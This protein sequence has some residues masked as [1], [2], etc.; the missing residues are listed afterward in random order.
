[1]AIQLVIFLIL[2]FASAFT[3]KYAYLIMSL[4]PFSAFILMIVIYFLNFGLNKKSLLSKNGFV[5]DV[6]N[7]RIEIENQKFK[8]TINFDDGYKCDEYE[9]MLIIIKDKVPQMILPIRAVDPDYRADIQAIIA[10]GTTP[11]EQ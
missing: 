6:F 5:V 11:Y 4:I 7:D 8:K 9:N 2:A 10:A 1:M 3:G